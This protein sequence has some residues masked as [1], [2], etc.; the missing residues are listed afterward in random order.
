MKKTE[1][2]NEKKINGQKKYIALYGVTTALLVCLIF[3][4]V[5]YRQ[6]AEQLKAVEE[7]IKNA[8]SA[9]VLLTSDVLE[10]QL[11]EYVVDY[12]E[13]ETL[14]STIT[15]EDLKQLTAMI[16][17]EVINNLPSEF[18]EEELNE[19]RNMIAESVTEAVYEMN[20]SIESTNEEI[21]IVNDSLKAY[22][23]KTIVPRLTLLIEINTGRIDDLKAAFDAFSA[24]YATEKNQFNV[25]IDDIYARLQNISQTGATVNDITIV[26]NN[27]EELVNV[28]NEYIEKNDNRITN[29]ENELAIVE[30]QIVQVQKDLQTIFQEQLNNI[31]TTLTQQVL[32]NAEI[33]EEERDFILSI[34]ESLN[35]DTVKSFEDAKAQLEEALANSNLANSEALNNAI[36]GLQ[37]SLDDIYEELSK[38]S[39]DLSEQITNNSNEINN[40]YNRL[41]NCQFEYKDGHLYAHYNVGTPDAV[42]FRL[43]Y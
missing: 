37:S 3:S 11:K 2:T 40:I 28:M 32:D 19:I 7:D 17:S 22:I 42:S 36:G 34:I 23:D 25:T 33:S 18:S 30:E 41:G 6:Q 27:I 14:S 8:Y 12:F 9:G 5:G 38:Q 29:V 13:T 43:D 31:K 26:N 4:F 10:E 16:S 24:T 20:S 35:S 21:T 15:D 1:N 39:S